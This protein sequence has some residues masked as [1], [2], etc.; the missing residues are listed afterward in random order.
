MDF[1]KDIEL[2]MLFWAHKTQQWSDNGIALWGRPFAATHGFGGVDERGYSGAAICISPSN[3]LRLPDVFISEG[4]ATQ[5]GFFWHIKNLNVESF[6]TPPF[7]ITDQMDLSFVGEY[8][9]TFECDRDWDELRNEDGRIEEY[10]LCSTD[11]IGIL[12]VEKSRSTQG[13]KITIFSNV[14]GININ[15]GQALRFADNPEES[16]GRIVSLSP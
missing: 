10:L 6:P 16:F 12:L 2:P 13:G 1:A 11:W 8:N 14:E 4:H 5:G 9:I 7:L 3:C 15:P